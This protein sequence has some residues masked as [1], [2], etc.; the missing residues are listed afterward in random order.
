M[1]PINESSEDYLETILILSKSLPVVR[2]IDIVNEMG[3]RKSSVSNALK[4]LKEKGHITVEKHGYIYLTEEGKEIA[5]S[6]YERH[7]WFTNWLI[8]LGV[9]KKTA[10]E[11]ACHLEH[12]LSKESFEAIKRGTK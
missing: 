2:A 12:A 5:E 6:T 7:L 3:F 4:N 11:D 1:R 10:E 9:D 8:S